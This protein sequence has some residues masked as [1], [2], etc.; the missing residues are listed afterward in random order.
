MSAPALAD[1]VSAQLERISAQLAEVV[2][3]QQ[4]ARAERER[5]AEL[6]H[7]LSPVAQAVMGLATDE[8]EELSREV[9]VEDAVRFARTAARSLPRLEGLLAQ[10]DSVGELVHEVTS[11]AGAGVGSVSD[12]LAAAEGRGYFAAARNTAALA[13]RMVGELAVDWPTDPPSVRD[14]LRRLRDPQTR[15]GLARAICLLRALG[16]PAS[17]TP[18]KE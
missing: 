15:L 2:A 13:D 14:L 16:A 8:L 6:L 1:P 17:P 12:A 9:T 11:I 10:L 4:A 5:R 18:T 7:E 3:E